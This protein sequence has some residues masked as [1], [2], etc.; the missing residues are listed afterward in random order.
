VKWQYKR[1]INSE[2]FLLG[3]CSAL[4]LIFLLATIV[5]TDTSK[6]LSGYAVEFATIAAAALVAFYTLRGIRLQIEASFVSE[7]EALARKQRAARAALS[8]YPLKPISEMREEY[9]LDNRKAFEH[10]T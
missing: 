2:N 4:A 7:R 3:V 10:A 6:K 8:T 1:A 5:T 9:Y